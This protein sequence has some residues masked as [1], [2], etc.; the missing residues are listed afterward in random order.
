MEFKVL[1]IECLE[2][3]F[4]SGYVHLTAEHIESS[5]EVTIMVSSDDLNDKKYIKKELQEEYKSLKSNY[6]I[7]VGDIL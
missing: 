6:K 5:T 4:E 1:K 7:T 2:G 3:C